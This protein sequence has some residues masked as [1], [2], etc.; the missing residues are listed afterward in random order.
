MALSPPQRRERIEQYERGPLRLKAAL[1]QL[2]DR[3]VR[4]RPSADRWSAHERVCY[5]AD[6]ETVGA[7]RLR[8]LVAEKEPRLV[9]YDA[10]EWVRR[11][12]YLS[13]PLEPAI[14][15]IEAVR[16]N[17]TAL[18]KRLPVWAWT[19]EARQSDAG[20]YT[21]DDWLTTYSDHLD[22]HAREIELGFEA[23]QESS[24]TG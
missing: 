19:L 9:G 8:Y 10:E 20:I 2:P 18:L 22:R 15:T 14:I 11:L 23:W 12:D 13:H 6:A 1:I 17:T 4:W 16:A 21:I 3:V 5:C 7:S 24:K